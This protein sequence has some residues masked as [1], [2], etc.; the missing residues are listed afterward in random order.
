MLKRVATVT[1]VLLCC[2]AAALAQGTLTATLT[3]TVIQGSFT[4]ETPLAQGSVAVCSLCD[5]VLYLLADAARLDPLAAGETGSFSVDLAAADGAVLMTDTATQTTQALPGLTQ[6]QREQFLTGPLSV[7]VYQGSD[8]PENPPLAEAAVP[9]PAAAM[10]L[11]SAGIQNGVLGDEYGKKGSQKNK[12]IPT[13]S[14]P[15]TVQNLPQGT[16]ALAVTIVDPD[17]GDWVHWLAVNI[18]PVGEIPQNASIDWAEQMVQGKNDF[19]QRGYG[20]PTPPSGTHTYVIT[21]YALSEPLALK[22][23]FRVWK[24]DEALE[25]KVLG[26]VTLTGDYSR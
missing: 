8:T 1:V 24:L 20:G 23:G 10:T 11:N 16:A 17:G 4:A 2:V 5:T 19:G 12:G 18:P 14:P 9:A 22:A 15:L 7:R 3:G 26:Q 6:A 21:V 13:L 25:G